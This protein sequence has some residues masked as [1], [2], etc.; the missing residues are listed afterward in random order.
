MITARIFGGHGVAIAAVLAL[1]GALP[2]AAS[3]A[4]ISAGTGLGLFGTYTPDGGTTLD[5]ATGL[6]FAAPALIGIGANDFAFSVG[7]EATFSNFDYDPASSGTIFTFAG[8]GR[9]SASSITIDFQTATQLILSMNGTY[10][11]AGFDD[12]P[13]TFVL[14]A[15]ALGDLYTFSGSGDVV[16]PIPGALL[17]FGSALFGLGLTRRR[18]S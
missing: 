12:T 16:I 17:L 4:T 9:F 10:S 1:A 6:D 14:T 7:G 11:L 3:A 5:V 15:D 13:G 8:G 18:N 2:V